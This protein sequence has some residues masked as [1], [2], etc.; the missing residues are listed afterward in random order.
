MVSDPET[1]AAEP[2]KPLNDESISLIVLMFRLICAYQLTFDFIRYN[3]LS[4]FWKFY[5]EPLP[6]GSQYIQLLNV[7]SLLQLV[8]TH[9]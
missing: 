2:L 5:Q 9:V 4:Y 7:A 8:S 1:L 6:Y 3:I